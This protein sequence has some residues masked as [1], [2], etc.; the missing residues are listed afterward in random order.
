MPNFIIYKD[1]AYNFYTTVADGA[2]YESA[3][4]LEQVEEVT[5]MEQGEEGLRKL[6][7]RLERAQKTGCSGIDWTL[8]D[9]I[10][11]NRAGIDETRMSRKE[12]I[13]KYLTLSK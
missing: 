11:C 9:C 10:E 13:K 5:K 4:T 12:F 7:E 6:P 2:C 8:A 1:G 3:L